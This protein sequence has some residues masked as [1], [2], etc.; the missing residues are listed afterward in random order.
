MKRKRL[1]LASFFLSVTVVLLLIFDLNACVQSQ[2]RVQAQARVSS[3]VSFDSIIIDFKESPTVN[4]A[5]SLEALAED[6][7][8]SAS[9]NS[10]FSQADNVYIIP[11]DRQLL[12]QFLQSELG[13]Q[14]ESIEPNFL[15]TTA[16]FR[17]PPN[18]PDY[19]RQWNFQRI[20]VQDAWRVTLGEG[21]TVA[22][23]DTGV[24]QVPDLDNTAFVPGYD[25]VND[26]RDARDDNGHGTHV[27]GTIAQSTNNNYGVTGIVPGARIM[28][29]KVLSRL[30]SGTTADIAEAVKF[31]ADNGADVINMSLGGGAPSLLF[32][33][34][35][36]YAHSKGVVIVAAAGNNGSSQ[37]SYPARYSHVIGVSAL[38]DR[39]RKTPYSNYGDGIDIAAP[40]GWTRGDR[41]ELGG[42]LQETVNPGGNGSS[43]KY[44]QGTSM[45]SPHVAG[46]AAALKSLG[47]SSPDRVE[48]ILKESARRVRDDPN[49]YYG[50]GRL[51]AGAAVRRVSG[52]VHRLPLR[53]AIA[54]IVAAVVLTVLSWQL[55]KFAWNA[56]FTIGLVLGGIGLFPLKGLTF[57]PVPSW[58]A[59]LAGSS[60]PE[61]GGVFLRGGQ[62]NP[63]TASLLPPFVLTLFLLGQPVG[64]WFAIGV[65][66]GTSSFLA[67]SLFSNTPVLWLGSGPLTWIYL[68]TN[69][70]L[71][72][73][74]AQLALRSAKER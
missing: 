41:G 19:D 4:V 21:V 35:I 23:I 43:F 52:I 72:F 6:F 2:S 74:L 55:C 63:L 49:N 66:V 20:N 68:G 36:G 47:V 9:L 70:A 46:V 18:D 7:G 22:V 32:Q 69:S 17:Q 13:S 65:T 30:G 50:A 15:Y 31:A 58:L 39:D 61:L 14:A 28:P 54:R 1:F 59:N 62:L 44:L 26:R 12:E 27:A 45:A 48:T 67:I 5:D 37:V 10:E 60:I 38:D 71:C 11:G 42:I 51:D 33:E 34:A 24:T 40:G 25:F 56:W 53:Q 73:C 64:R 16:S 57:L 3:G 29:L 8:V